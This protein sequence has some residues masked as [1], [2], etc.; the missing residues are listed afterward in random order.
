MKTSVFALTTALLAC[1][2]SAQADAPR[3]LLTNVSGKV[4]VNTGKGYTQIRSAVKILPGS[5]VFVS[6]GAS[7]AARFPTCEVDL[8]AGTVTRLIETELCL[9]ASADTP[10]SL[11]GTD[12]GIFITPTNGYPPPPPPPAGMLISPY[13]IAGGIFTAGA[14]AVSTTMFENNSSPAP[15]SGP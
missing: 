7:V 1:A 10:I 13:V 6:E 12:E 15:V 14:L 2:T 9:Q 3:V 5:T 4:L 11:R 8:I